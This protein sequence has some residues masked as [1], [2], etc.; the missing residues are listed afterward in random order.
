MISRV[1][2]TYEYRPSLQ[3]ELYQEISVALWKALAKFDQQS[4]LKTYVLSIAY[5]RAV[6]HVARHAREANT[7][8][9]DAFEIH[10]DFCPS[11]VMGENQQMQR[12]VNGLKN[13]PLVDRQ[14]ITLALEG[15]SYQDIA[16]ILGIS[17][18]NVGVKLNRAKSKL[19]QMLTEEYSA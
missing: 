7:T 15:E 13:L 19:S 14:L 11:I 18:N 10:G 9:I 4:S 3:E 12:L 16:T 8:P 17:V 5:N 2:C 6:S 1:I